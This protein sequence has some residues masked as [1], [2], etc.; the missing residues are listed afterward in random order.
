MGISTMVIPTAG[1]I[2]VLLI[3][4]KVAIRCKQNDLKVG[5]KTQKPVCRFGDFQYILLL[6]DNLDISH[7]YCLLGRN[8]SARSNGK[9]KIFNG[10]LDMISLNKG[11]PLFSLSIPVSTQWLTETY[12][13]CL[14]S[15][16]AYQLP[17]I[18]SVCKKPIII[19]W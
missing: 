19:L 14:H 4:M 18:S 3:Q 11:F 10:N 9:P 8:V 2:I 16:L 6:L 1:M 5:S 13:T 15:I 7:M 17:V 12:L